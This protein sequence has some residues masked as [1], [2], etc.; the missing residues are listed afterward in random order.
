MST[1]P[2]WLT[3]TERDIFRALA[4]AALP[5][6]TT[7]PGAGD[8]S[9]RR[10]EAFLAELPDG[11][12]AGWRAGLW[13]L[14]LRAVPS[15]GGRFSKLPLGRRLQVMAA[16]DATHATRLALRGLITPLKVTH[17]ESPQAYAALGLRHTVPPPAQRETKR[18]REQISDA[19]AQGGDVELECEAVV[20]GTGAGGAPVAAELASRG[21]AVL[22]LEEGGY[23]ERQDFNGRPSEMMRRLY[24]QAGVTVAW[25][26]TGIPVPVGKAVGGT[27]LIN[28]GTCFKTPD[29]VLQQWAAQGLT[30]LAPSSFAPYLDRVWSELEV[31]PSSK[32]A[33]GTVAT[34]VARGADALGWSH[35]PLDRNAPGCDGQGLCCFG[36]PTDAKRS[37]NVSWVPKALERGAQVLTG[38]RVRRVL[39]EGDRAVG[40]EGT[41]TSP[42][43]REVKVTVRAKVVVVACGSLMTPAL[44]LSQGLCNASGE[45]GQNLSIH[46]AAA[47]IGVYGEEVGGWRAVPQGYAVDHFK[48][49]GLYFEG[50]TTP[51]ELHAGALWGFGPGY[52]RLMEEYNRSISFGFMVK[53][54]SRGRVRAGA[55]GEPLMTYWLNDHDVRTLHRGLGLLARLFFAGGAK[56]VFVP[57]GGWDRLRNLSDVDAFE[58]ARGVAARHLDLTAYHPLGTAHMGVDPFRSVVGPDHETHDVHNLYVCDGSA[59]PGPPGV[60]PQITIMAMALR[61][62]DAIAVRLER[63]QRA[64]A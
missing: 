32:E 31:G 4:E 8:D 1:T 17:F 63:L 15:F 56:E 42:D 57:V 20:V 51:L 48:D 19:G 6:G 24:R 9:L 14:E 2:S 33:L 46:P 61:A 22:M 30:G 5:G 59:V 35:H 54:T 26:N 39:L 47:G 37:T 60:N 64:A 41:A 7:L 10:T 11:L 53:D 13:A 38:V 62:A 45:L 49:E 23:H 50:A 16:W 44:L 29:A 43:G 25:G 3:Q 18:W 27:T 52:M 28:S 55:G 21:L 36:C 40:V 58:R 12:R 34:L